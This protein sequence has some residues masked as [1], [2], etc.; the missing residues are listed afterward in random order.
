MSKPPPLSPSP[1]SSPTPPDPPQPV[2][3]W[4]FKWHLAPWRMRSLKFQIESSLPQSTA[5]LVWKVV[6]NHWL[7]L[8][9]REREAVAGELIEHFQTAEARGVGAEQAVRAF[10]PI[11]KAVRRF[12]RE[13]IRQRWWLWRWL[14]QLQ[15]FLSVSY[16]LAVPIDQIVGQPMLYRLVAG[17]DGGLSPL[18]YSVGADHDDDGGRLPINPDGDPDSDSFRGRHLYQIAFPDDPIPDGDWV[19]FPDPRP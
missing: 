11:K 13:K 12:R 5:K 19:L 6:K 10:G 15:L 17:A 7:C 4:K 3:W 14:T 2:S 1:T 9:L 8:W 16:L 18:V